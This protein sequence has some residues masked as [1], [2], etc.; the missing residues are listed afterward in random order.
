MDEDEVPAYSPCEEYG[1]DWFDDEI[2]HRCRD[3]GHQESL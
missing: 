2:P 3:C 1:H